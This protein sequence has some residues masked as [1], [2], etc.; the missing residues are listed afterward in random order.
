MLGDVSIKF[1]I[2]HTLARIIWDLEK[3]AFYPQK[4]VPKVLNGLQFKSVKFTFMQACSD[5][6]HIIDFHQ[7][8]LWSNASPSIKKSFL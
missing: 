4:Q 1:D 6:D 8:V 3:V 2:R 7:V 5:V